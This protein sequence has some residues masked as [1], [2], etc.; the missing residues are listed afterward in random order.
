MLFSII[1]IL[2]AFLLLLP[3]HFALAGG[4]R[5]YSGMNLYYANLCILPLSI[6]FLR[7]EGKNFILQTKQQFIIAIAAFAY[8]LIRLYN[9]DLGALVSYGC[10]DAANHLGI[11]RTFLNSDP[12]TYFGFNALYVTWWF[13]EAV[14]GLSITSALTISL[15]FPIFSLAYLI[16]YFSTTYSASKKEILKFLVFIIGF[17]VLSESC[18]LPLLHYNQAD[19]YL[20]HLYSVSAFLFVVFFGAKLSLSALLFSIAACRFSYSLQLPDLL[21]CASLFLAISALRT[22]KTFHKAIYSIS[23]I[24]LL[25]AAFLGISKLLEVFSLTGSILSQNLDSAFAA[26]I[27]GIALLLAGGF[28][29]SFEVFF[30]LAAIIIQAFW[31]IATQ[32]SEYYF[33]KL[34]LYSSLA[35][36]IIALRDLPRLVS[37]KSILRTASWVTLVS[38]LVLAQRP[39]MPSYLER[40]VATGSYNLISPLLDFKVREIIDEVLN[41]TNK[42]FAGYYTSRW[43]QY[44]FF[45]VL[46]N[47]NN[48]FDS[49]LAPSKI[50]PQNSCI[51]WTSNTNDIPRL[52]KYPAPLAID[53]FNVINQ[54][55]DA[56]VVKYQVD[57]AG[58]QIIKYICSAEQEL[59]LP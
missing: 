58:R 14:V 27:A 41:S 4:L 45:N 38:L 51:F 16:A 25:S 37:A 30:L 6:L 32:E 33:S 56:K 21:I 5:F 46:Y 42:T 44:S 36:I 52:E 40:S 47:T 49:F 34:F 50:L 55:K 57:W 15:T 31:L 29:L 17:I 39:Y 23:S 11:Y 59:S 28:T 10:A 2:F 1:R 9:S 22:N 13:F 26:Q 8:F 35:L 18:L 12:K 48:S 20:G 43:A 19:G 3:L 7:K 24:A 53:W 54:R